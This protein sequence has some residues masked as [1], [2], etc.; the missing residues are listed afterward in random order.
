MAAY[1]GPESPQ[2][3]SVISESRQHRF[4]IPPIPD[5][6]KFSFGEAYDTKMFEMIHKYLELDT[7][8]RL[9]YVGSDKGSFAPQIANKFCLLEPIT[10]VVPGHFHYQETDKKSVVPI[11]ISHVGAEEYFRKEAR[12]YPKPSMFERVLL[13]ESVHYLVDARQTYQHILKTLSECGRIL[14]V[15]RPGPLT[16]LPYFRDAKERLANTDPDYINIIKDLQSCNLDVKWN[17]EILPVVMPKIKWFAMLQEKFPS[18][19][20]VISNFEIVS[21]MRELSEGML[22]YEGDMV[23]F[24]D[25]LLFITAV[26]SSSEIGIPMV[27]R[28]GQT[29][30]RPY[31]GLEE[32]KYTLPV[33]P[34]VKNMLQKKEKKE[35]KNRS[36]FF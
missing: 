10:T 18:Q 33:T 21:G 30:S 11:R 26:P 1:L 35:Q 5:Y 16:T 12:E 20:E 13:M 25:R 31:P 29:N 15:H 14:I 24:T 27:Q 17:L 22:K 2:P 34:E 4:N 9:C 19:M 8:H 6:E 32:L 28:F 23:E 3:F 7:Y 36:I